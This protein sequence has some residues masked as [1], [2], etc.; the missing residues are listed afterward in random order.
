YDVGRDGSV[1]YI[2]M[3]NV[4]GR[5]LKDKIRD[6]AP[7]KPSVAVNLARQVLE[8]LRHAHQHGV[9]HRDIKPQNILLTA[10]GQVK[11]TDFGIARAVGASTLADTEG[12]I[13]TAHYLSPEQ[14]KGRFT[15]AQTDPYSHGVVLY[16]VL[17]GHL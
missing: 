16:A 4:D 7:L 9:V 10:T 15:G 2:V 1:D 17:A 6:E 14:A 12:V 13:G 8:A 11:V 5:T 3:E